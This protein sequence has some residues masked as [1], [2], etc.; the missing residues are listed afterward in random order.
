VER[1][2]NLIDVAYTIDNFD[3]ELSI[4]VIFSAFAHLRKY[5]KKMH[6]FGENPILIVRM[7]F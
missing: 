2:I 4:S 3:Q 5:E 7:L 1:L 6:H